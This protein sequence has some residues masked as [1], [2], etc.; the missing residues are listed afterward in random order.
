MLLRSISARLASLLVFTW[1]GSATATAQ[2]QA[3]AADT[4]KKTAPNSDLPIIPTR[5]AAFTTDEGT[6]MSLDVSPDG[7]TI[8]FDLVGDL[9]TLPL[10]GGK[11]TRI[12]SGMAFDGQPRY[13]PDGSTIVFVSDRS[14]Y[15]NLWLIDANGQNPRALTKDKD[16]QYISP[17]WTPDGKYLVV[18]RTK[19]GI[20][21][22]RYDLVLMN[23]DGGSGLQ[24]TGP[25]TQSAPPDPLAPPPFN[26]Y[27]G[28][29]VAPDNR[30]IYAAIK[31]GGFKYDQMLDDR[32]QLGVYDR[33]TG[34]TYLRTTNLGGGMRPAVSP[35]GKWLAYAS[36]IDSKTALRL[37][38]LASGDEVVLA[39][40]I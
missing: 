21:G 31:R 32:W 4:A 14:G 39:R 37:R 29:M 34:K 20:L 38:N 33:T 12:T 5:Q 28:A 10:A 17:A 3:G 24:L 2:Q 36:R 22:S 40:D 25:G 15:E 13:S 1:L 16:A 9:Y 27:M 11:A 7:K 19:T 35:D 8:V 6:W 30:Y 23:K 18:S 26:N